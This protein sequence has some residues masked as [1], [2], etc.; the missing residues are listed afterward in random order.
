M[1][2]EPHPDHLT[3]AQVGVLWFHVDVTRRAGARRATPTAPA[4]T[5]SRRRG[6]VLE[7]L[8]ELEA[9]LNA[10]PPAPYADASRIRSTSTRA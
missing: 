4:S 10:D 5:R 2:T 3:I 9:E 7:A 8:R 6:A 1:I